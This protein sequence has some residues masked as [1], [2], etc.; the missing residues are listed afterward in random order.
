MKY[1]NWTTLVLT[2]LLSGYAHAGRESGGGDLQCD[3]K[4]RS[5]TA[6]IQTWIEEKGPESGK[7]LDLSSSRNSKTA[8]P[9]TVSQYEQSMSALL[10]E[11]LDSSCVSAGD[12]GYPIT[13]D[14]RPK[15]CSSFSDAQG[16][17][18]QCQADL[19]LNMNADEQIEQIHHE[20]AIHIPGLEPDYGPISTYKI[21]TQLSAFTADVTERK[22][23]VM[24]PP[25]A[26]LTT[27]PAGSLE[28]VGSPG[29]YQTNQVGINYCETNSDGSVKI[30]GCNSGKYIQL[31]QQIGVPPGLYIVFYSESYM[32]VI[33]KPGQKSVVQ[34]KSLTVPSSDESLQTEVAW[35]LT[36]SSMQDLLLWSTFAN[37]DSGGSFEDCD[38]SAASAKDGHCAVLKSTDYHSFLNTVIQ[39]HVP[40]GSAGMYDERIWDPCGDGSNGGCSYFRGAGV[41][42]DVAN[43]HSGDA[44]SVFPGTYLLIQTEPFTGQRTTVFG[45]KVP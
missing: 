32:R 14:G 8:A 9:Y 34:L 25:S 3:A 6:N 28:V 16:V 40:H 41:Y 45:V 1:L 24:P 36:D 13:V 35:D 33:V 19:L 42:K 7:T 18:I 37:P 39:F 31:N 4:I 38:T 29:K 17:H 30:F 15:V 27:G 26:P 5:I 11:T 44:I 22:L 10:A 23:V 43:V 21:S 20:F 12:K 2:I